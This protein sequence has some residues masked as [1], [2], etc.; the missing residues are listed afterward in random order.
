MSERAGGMRP[1]ASADPSALARARPLDPRAPLLAFGAVAIALVA[2]TRPAWLAGE[3]VITLAAVL[4]VGHGRRLLAGLRALAL[5]ALVI[6]VAGWLEAGPLVAAMG[7]A[8]LFG[9]CAAGVVLLALAPPEELAEALRQWGLPLRVSFIV[10]AGLRCVPLVARTFQDV[11]AAQEARGI[12]FT[13]FWRHLRAYLALLIPVLREVFCIA[14]QL[15][16]A[17]EGRGFSATPR[18]PPAGY[19]W[20]ARETLLVAAPWG[21]LLVALPLGR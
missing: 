8:R 21:A 19:A 7:I 14:E 2:T 16:Q 4:F 6:A 5:F 12:R 17:L 20:R 11:R 1:D 9:L 13:P 3:V 15:A 18:T 10:G